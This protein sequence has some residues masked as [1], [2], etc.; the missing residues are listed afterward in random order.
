[1]FTVKHILGGIDHLYQAP[2]VRAGSLREQSGK[3]SDP[4][5]VAFEYGGET[6]TLRDGM[7]W[8][9][10]EGGKTVG[11]YDLRQTGY[12]AMSVGAGSITV[13]SVNSGPDPDLLTPQGIKPKP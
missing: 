9:M 1:M 10:N 13:T 4:D 11:K 3:I 7:I 6:R 2:E 5:F 12:G 8:I